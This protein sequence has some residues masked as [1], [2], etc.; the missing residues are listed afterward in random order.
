RRSSSAGITELHD[1]RR[2]RSIE[3]LRKRMRELAD[4]LGPRDLDTAVAFGEFLKTRRTARSFANH[5]AAQQA[6]R[7]EALTGADSA[8]DDDSDD[9]VDDGDDLRDDLAQSHQDHQRN[10]V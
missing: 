8:D 2:G 7:D 1:Y 9:Q 6:R 3:A 10:E 5:H 4:L